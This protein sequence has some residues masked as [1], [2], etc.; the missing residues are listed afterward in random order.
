MIDKEDSR[1]YTMSN[2]EKSLEEGYMK[3]LV[4]LLLVLAL[5]LGCTSAFA[6]GKL[7]VVQENTCFINEYSPYFYAYA[8]VENS[9]DKPIK[10]NAGVLEVY[11]AEGDPISSTDCITAG[12]RYLQPGEYTYVRMNTY[13]GLGD[14]AV[15]ADYAMTLTGK[16]EKDYENVRFQVEGKLEMNVQVDK[17]STYNYMYATVTNNTEETLYNVQVMMALLDAEGNVLHVCEDSLYD[18]GIPAGGSVVFRRNISSDFMNYFEANSITPASVDAIA[19][20]EK[21]VD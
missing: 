12:A 20:I 6:A 17:W 4:S 5:C 19:F 3:K 9:G 16:T 2:P 10:V 7:N 8:K 11:D 13:D 21:S 15:P 18:V 1:V 14:D